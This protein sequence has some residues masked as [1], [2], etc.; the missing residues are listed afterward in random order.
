MKLTAPLVTTEG[1]EQTAQIDLKSLSK[2]E[3]KL[4][5]RV[6]DGHKAE[7]DLIEKVH[8]HVSDSEEFNS[9]E[10]E[11][12]SSVNSYLRVV[13]IDGVDMDDSDEPAGE[14]VVTEVTN[15]HLTKF[16]TNLNEII[17]KKSEEAHA[18]S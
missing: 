9:A 15:G 7:V 17:D 6:N 8:S 18:D 16:M 12:D 13:T 14:A 1:T 10:L 5:K 11:I 2:D 4:V 3:K